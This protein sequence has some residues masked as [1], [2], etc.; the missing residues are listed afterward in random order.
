MKPLQIIACLLSLSLVSWLHA[1]PPINTFNLPTASPSPTPPPPELA[2]YIAQGKAA[3]VRG[4]IE[5][6]KAAFQMA[7]QIDSRNQVA[8]GYLRRIKMDQQTKPKSE[9][10]EKQL[11]TVIIPQIQFHDA[12]LGSALEYLKN[13]VKRETNGRQAVNFVVQLPVEQMNTKTVTLN[14]TNVP[15]TE[16]LRY[17]GTVASLNFQFDKYAIL[18]KPTAEF[19]PAPAPVPAATTATP[20]IPGQ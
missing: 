18:V 17:L 11:A 1:A 5:G 19:T 15:F 20:A 2:E 6:A 4:D 12:T 3:Y 16:A 9:P 13:A 14:L 7:Y 10:I 8:I